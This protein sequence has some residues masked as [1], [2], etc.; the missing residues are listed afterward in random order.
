M[1]DSGFVALTGVFRG[2]LEGALALS[3][4][5]NSALFETSLRFDGGEETLESVGGY[6]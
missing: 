2:V 6:V 4:D 3:M 5:E 1:G